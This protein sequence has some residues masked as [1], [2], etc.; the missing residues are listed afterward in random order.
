ME[1]LDTESAGKILPCKT[2]D[3][4]GKFFRNGIFWEHNIWFVVGWRSVCWE[5]E[6]EWK[7]DI[8]ITFYVPVKINV[9]DGTFTVFFIVLHGEQ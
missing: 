6:F 2:T 9:A 7:F 8:D 4:E 5:S 3:F 1:I